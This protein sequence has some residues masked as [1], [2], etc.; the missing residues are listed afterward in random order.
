MNMVGGGRD[1]R[2][3]VTVGGILDAAIVMG[4]F[5]GEKGV[6]PLAAC[7]LGNELFVDAA[8]RFG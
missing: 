4:F 8:S 1:E 5:A 7:E 3:C 6:L 2:C